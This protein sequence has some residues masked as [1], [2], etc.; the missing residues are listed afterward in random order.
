MMCLYDN[1]RIRIRFAIAPII[2]QK[3]YFFQS[4]LV[5]PNFY[6]LVSL[7]MNMDTNHLLTS[8]V[9]EVIERESL[10]RKLASGKKLRIKLGAD[11]TAPDLHL[12]HAI[13]LNKLRE[14]QELGHTV[15]FILA[16]IRR[17]SAI[18][19]GNQK[20]DQRFLMR[21][22]RKMQKRTLRRQEK[23]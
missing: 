10:E 7:M 11:P 1:S 19:R 6:Y 23:F 5:L 13:V 21:K 17:V 14:F 12:G 3:H 15:V 4:I 22:L 2:P 8:C 20:H 9:E 18:R 16:I